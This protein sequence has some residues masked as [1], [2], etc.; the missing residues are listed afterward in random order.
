LPRATPTAARLEPTVDEAAWLA[1][2]PAK[3]LNPFWSMRLDAV[4]ADLDEFDV[5]IEKKRY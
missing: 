4:L 2:P 3:D 1:A 5:I